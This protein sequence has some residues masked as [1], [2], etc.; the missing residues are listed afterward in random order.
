M[1]LGRKLSARDMIAKP[2]FPA[3]GV[4]SRN[5]ADPCRQLPP[6][7]KRSRIGDAR[8]YPLATMA[9]M[10]GND[11]KPAADVVV[12]APDEDAPLRACDPIL[13]IAHLLDE[14]R[15]YFE[16]E[17]REARKLR[18]RR[19]Q[20]CVTPLLPCDTMTELRQMGAKCF[21]QRLAK[22]VAPPVQYEHALLICALPRH[23]AHRGRVTASQIAPHPRRRSSA[24]EY[25]FT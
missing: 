12:A 24:A 14:K 15:Q 17:W 9:P 21:S 7:S 10:R 1:K 22:R 20:A 3:A 5:Q 8:H 25:G 18:V 6:R 23:E 16:S 11:G 4:L 13:E 2:V 19:A